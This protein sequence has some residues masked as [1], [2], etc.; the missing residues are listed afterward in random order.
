MDISIQD[1][2]QY[3]IQSE[4]LSIDDL[5]TLNTLKVPLTIK[6]DKRV[7]TLREASL[8]DTDEEDCFDRYTALA[9]RVLKV[10]FN[11]TYH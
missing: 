3:Y 5:R 4:N 6:E 2:F 1:C 8:L 10:K 11:C 7:R 9:S